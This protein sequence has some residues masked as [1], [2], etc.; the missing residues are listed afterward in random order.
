MAFKCKN[1]CLRERTRRTNGRRAYIDGFRRC[2]ICAYWLKTDAHHC[3]CCGCRLRTHVPPGRARHLRETR[4][5]YR[6]GA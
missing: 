2:T 4:H 6:K 5:L 3:P 1:I